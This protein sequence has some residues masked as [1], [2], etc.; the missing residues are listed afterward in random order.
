MQNNT[1]FFNASNAKIVVRINNTLV[2]V[3]SSAYNLAKLLR[4]HNV[5]AHTDT[6]LHSS[7]V[8]FASEEGFKTDNCAHALI[9]MALKIVKKYN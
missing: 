3:A 6:I 9:D 2:G 1:V 8:D 4:K 7:D 5:N